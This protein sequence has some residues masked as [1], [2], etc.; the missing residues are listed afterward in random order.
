MVRTHPCSKSKAIPRHVPDRTKKRIALFGSVYHGLLIVISCEI[1]SMQI[2]YPGSSPRAV[3][4]A[5]MGWA[6]GFSEKKRKENPGLV[7]APS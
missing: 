3:A 2:S 6:E 5:A 1:K 4:G 7:R